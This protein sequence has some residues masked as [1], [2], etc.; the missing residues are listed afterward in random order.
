MAY[1]FKGLGEPKIRPQHEAQ[2]LKTGSKES[3]P[4]IDTYS[5]DIDPADFFDPEEFGVRRRE[6]KSFD[7]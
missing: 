7:P 1:G 6:P 2:A 3:E 4:A 5:E